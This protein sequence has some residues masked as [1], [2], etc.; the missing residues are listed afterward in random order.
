MIQQVFFHQFFIHFSIGYRAI[1]KERAI[2][3]SE[4]FDNIN[5]RVSCTFPV[6]TIFFFILKI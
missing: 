1:N 3:L 5:Q 6:L 4:R 2:H